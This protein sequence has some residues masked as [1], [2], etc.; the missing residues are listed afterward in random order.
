MK[1]ID[2]NT[3]ELFPVTLDK[4]EMNDFVLMMDNKTKETI[5]TKA[6]LLRRVIGNLEASLKKYIKENVVIDE[7]DEGFFGDIRVQKVN[8]HR[9]SETKL[10]K[11]GSDK[12]IKTWL[13]LKEKYSI[14]KSLLK[15]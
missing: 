3:G 4:K 5:F 1:I 13:K 9:F 15:I 7:D 11:E 14:S 10:L 2:T 12:D 8:Y 6:N